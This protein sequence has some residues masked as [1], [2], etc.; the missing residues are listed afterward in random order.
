MLVVLCQTIPTR[1]IHDRQEPGHDL[2][3]R[4][5]FSRCLPSEC[6]CLS[7]FNSTC[8]F[9]VQDCNPG[10]AGKRDADAVP[11]LAGKYM[12]HPW[13]VDC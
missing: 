6:P 5:G 8:S 3:T 1:S 9:L 2:T 7:L 12:Q 13:K 4:K 11:S 10:L